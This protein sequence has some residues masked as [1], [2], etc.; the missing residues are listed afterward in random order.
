LEDSFGFWSPVLFLEE[1][2][3]EVEKEVE[4]EEEE[5]EEAETVVV[6]GIGGQSSNSWLSLSAYC[7]GIFVCEEANVIIWIKDVLKLSTFNLRAF[8]LMLLVLYSW[9]RVSI[10]CAGPNE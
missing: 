5:E 4:E 8:D 10:A 1:V 2:E 7:W 3:E 9:S 6:W